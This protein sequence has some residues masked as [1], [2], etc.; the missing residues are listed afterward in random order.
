MSR[1]VKVGMYLLSLQLLF[2]LVI[3]NKVDIDINICLGCT[4]LPWPEIS[5]LAQKNLL[6]LVYVVMLGA[7]A[8]FYT[9]FVSIISDAKD[10]PIRIGDLEDKNAEHLVFLATYIILFGWVQFG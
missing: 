8:V 10:G 3:V 6:L 2:V 7:S 9:V 1:L 4:Y 5:K